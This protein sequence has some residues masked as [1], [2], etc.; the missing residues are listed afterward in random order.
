[1]HAQATT[2]PTA[3]ELSTQLAPK[4]G[5]VTGERQDPA[6]QYRAMPAL[7]YISYIDAAGKTRKRF[8]RSFLASPDGK[9]PVLSRI[10]Y[11]DSNSRWRPA[12]DAATGRP[13]MYSSA[14]QANYANVSNTFQTGN[15]RYVV[16]LDSQVLK[17]PNGRRYVWR[18]YSSNGGESWHSGKAYIDMAGASVPAG[19][20][21]HI[22]QRVVHL[23]DGSLVTPLYVH[24]TAGSPNMAVHLLTSTKDGVAWKR[25]ATVFRS[26][27]ANYSESTVTRRSDGRLLVI[28]R[29][30]VVSGRYLRSKLTA[31]VTNKPVNNAADLRAATWGTPYPVK[32]PG[33]PDSSGVRGVAPVVHT[34]DG[35]VLMLIF[36]RPSNQITLSRDGGRTWA[37]THRFYTNAPSGCSGGRSR[38]DGTYIACDDLGSSGY[39][40]VAVTSP[41]TVYVMGDNCQSWGCDMKGVRYPHG[42]TDLLWLTTIR[43]A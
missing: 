11:Q 25:S 15:G 17:E 16:A 20:Y 22:F 39:M 7:Q 38:G 1:M 42:T 19:A 8:I 5:A 2:Q 21:G 34:M 33:A 4:Y 9:T 31:R 35:G 36:G 3:A 12:K 18:R 28:S 13:L 6:Y 30:D 37:T 10:Q 43:L 26:S 32:V 40:G 14:V 23:P 24:H 27:T 29:Y 41:R